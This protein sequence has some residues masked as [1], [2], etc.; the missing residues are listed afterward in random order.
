M[1]E[2]QVETTLVNEEEVAYTRA[3][4]VLDRTGSKAEEGPS[5]PYVCD[6]GRLRENDAVRDDAKG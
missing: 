2:R 5:R 6:A 4:E 1:P 3:D